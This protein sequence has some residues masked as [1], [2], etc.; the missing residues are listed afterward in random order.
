M[1]REGDGTE[2]ARAKIDARRSGLYDGYGVP[3][4]LD[5][6]VEIAFIEVAASHRLQGIGT[7]IVSLL[8]D[9][10]R[11]ANMMVGSEAD[12]FWESLGWAEYRNLEDPA[13][14]RKLFIHWA[15]TSPHL[16]SFP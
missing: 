13:H 7:S 8:L 12:G 15:D 14:Y 2:I 5:D 16:E 3:A 4:S 10:Y 9:K 1:V 6:F 11:G